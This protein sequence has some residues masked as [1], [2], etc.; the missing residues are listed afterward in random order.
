M[1]VKTKNKTK[2]KQWNMT[3]IFIL[4]ITVG[5]QL[6]ST[7]LEKEEKPILFPAPDEIF[8]CLFPATDDL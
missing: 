3:E 4:I 7:L 2:Q 5:M 1:N 8:W 6:L